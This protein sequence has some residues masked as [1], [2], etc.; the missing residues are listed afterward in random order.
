MIDARRGAMMADELTQER[1]TFNAWAD[2][3]TGTLFTSGA[4][5]SEFYFKIWM[6]GYDA[7]RAAPASEEVQRVLDWLAKEEADQWCDP[8]DA[9]KLDMLREPYRDAREL[10][11]SL[12]RALAAAKADRESQRNELHV[13]RAGYETALKVAT[14]RAEAAERLLD[15]P[16]VADFLDGVRREA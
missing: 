12:S 15:T 1:K 6:A 13:I 3:M 11:L 9:A 4:K 16:E 5:S 10:I 14:A 7:L 2:A 8:D